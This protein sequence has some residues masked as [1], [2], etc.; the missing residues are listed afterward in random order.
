MTIAVKAAG[1]DYKIAGRSSLTLFSKAE[2]A[3][4]PIPL[5]ER[6]GLV[7]SDRDARGLLEGWSY[8]M[9]TFVRR[10]ILLAALLAL[11]SAAASADDKRGDQFI[12]AMDGNT[13]SGVTA[14]GLAFNLYFLAGGSTTYADAAGVKASGTWKLDH[15]G[16][17]CVHWPIRLDAMEGCFRI[18]FDGYEVSWRNKDVSGVGTLRGGVTSSFTK[19][20]RQ[21]REPN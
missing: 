10:G 19:S 12:T 16:N 8:Q 7:F 17:V 1:D 21:P 3:A 15:D 14:S 9:P 18:S 20:A 4:D 11:S 13:L 5:R 2:L 6:E